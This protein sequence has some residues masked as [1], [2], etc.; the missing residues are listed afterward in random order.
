M[1]KRSAEEF[2]KSI[3]LTDIEFSQSDISEEFIHD[4][5]SRCENCIRKKRAAEEDREVS[6]D[7]CPILCGCKI[8]I[9]RMINKALKD[10]KCYHGSFIR[11]REKSVSSKD[12]P[13]DFHM[14]IC[15]SRK[16][17]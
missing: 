7:E 9:E 3:I 16:G 6:D 15:L 14:N 5:C 1:D 2:F 12:D 17:P 4:F 11:I 8:C 10:R 13:F